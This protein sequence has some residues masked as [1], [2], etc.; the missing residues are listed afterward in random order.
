MRIGAGQGPGD[1]ARHQSS[2][3]V[4]D[5]RSGAI[6][7]VYHFAGAAPKSEAERHQA[8]LKGSHEA[9]GIALEHLAVLSN[10]DLPAGQG[11]LRVEPA[12]RRVV[13]SHVVHPSPLR[14]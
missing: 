11:E 12:S 7:G 1:A 5:V 4:Y 3:Y 14:P 2:H 13:R 10:P 8:L 6:V 9:S